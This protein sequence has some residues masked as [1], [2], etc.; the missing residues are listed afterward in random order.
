MDPAGED[1]ALLSPEQLAVTRILG[2]VVVSQPMRELV[3]ESSKDPAAF[4]HMVQ[5]AVPHRGGHLKK[6]AARVALLA[7]QHKLPALSVSCPQVFREACESDAP[8]RQAFWTTHGYPALRQL[9][10]SQRFSEEALRV[11]V[12]AP[13]SDS[14][15]S[16]HAPAS[17]RS[18]P[19]PQ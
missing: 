16:D 4:K 1:S 14:L 8:H 19:S 7:Q 15:V 18:S 11:C 10:R 12:P 17:L 3:H 5:E 9:F 6:W 2:E 13:V